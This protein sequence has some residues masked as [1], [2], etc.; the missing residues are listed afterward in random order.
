MKKLIFI[1]KLSL[2]TLVTVGALFPLPTCT[3]SGDTPLWRH[4]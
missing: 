3:S 4:L 2:V 1:S